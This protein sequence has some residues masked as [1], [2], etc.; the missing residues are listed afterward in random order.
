MF[1]ETAICTPEV[2]SEAAGS[3]SGADKLDLEKGNEAE[4]SGFVTVADCLD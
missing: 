1:A 4:A 3:G 2:F